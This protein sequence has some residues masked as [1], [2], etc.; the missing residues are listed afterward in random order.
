MYCANNANNDRHC[1]PLIAYMQV[2]VM[3]SSLTW[4]QVPKAGSTSLVKNFLILA[5]VD[6]AALDQG[7]KVYISAPILNTSFCDL[8]CK[9]H[10]AA[11]VF[12]HLLP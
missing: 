6:P 8:N 4:L 7:M 2:M 5:D 10:H 12:L 1:P 9:L 3:M 11:Q